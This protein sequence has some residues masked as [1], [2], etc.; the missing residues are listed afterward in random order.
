M[1]VSVV[2]PAYNEEPYIAACIESLLNQE[3]PAYEI[4][5]VDNNS[6][7]KTKEIAEKYSVKIVSEKKQ[8]ITFARNKG[9]EL[10]TGDII[11]RTDADTRVR[12]DWI[13][14]IKEHFKDK[15][16]LGLSGTIFF[17]DL[18]LTQ[19]SNWP[20]T[21]I[22]K[23]INS[24]LG[25]DALFGPNM[26]IRKS[27]WQLVKDEICLDDKKVHED[28]DLAIHLSYH[29]KIIFDKD[30]IVD[31]S[32]RR[33]KKMKPYFE[34]PY[35]YIKMLRFHKKP[36]IHINAQKSFNNMGKALN[37]VRKNSLNQISNII[38]L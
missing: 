5:I 7:D 36:L 24:I 8:G 21:L 37:N 4:I 26:A 6:T 19:Y 38:K 1:K 13:K 30:L 29:G 11:A 14:K 33:W 16:L 22:L 35:R 25:H 10:A 32:P 23:S 18:P 28:I 27:A 17:Y 31:S 9:F 15:D 12:K 3:E 20:T 34:Y 2:I